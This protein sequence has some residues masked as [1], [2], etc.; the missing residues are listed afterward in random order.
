MKAAM[1][2]AFC[3]SATTCSATVVL[4]DDSGPKISTMRPRGNPP[5]PSALSSEMEPDEMA[6]TCTMASFDPNRTMEPLPNCFSIWP[7]V[8]PRVRVRS[9]S[10]IKRSPSKMSRWRTSIV[11][12]F[13]CVVSLAGAHDQF[14]VP[15]H[16]NLHGMIQAVGSYRLRAIED[17]VLVPQLVGDV[18]EILVEIGSLEGEE[19][20]TAGFLGKVA[21]HLVTLGIDARDV[22]G[23]GVDVDVGLLGHFEGLI[24]CVAALVVLAIAQDDHGAAEFIERLIFHQFVAAGEEDGVI[25]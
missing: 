11:L 22:G 25:E 9:F 5:T 18:L 8:S 24:A 15:L 10:S 20:L 17:V 14:F 21:Q 3:A 16:T 1:P 23:D 6:A 4:P 12:E 7:S 19:R 2:P 13:R